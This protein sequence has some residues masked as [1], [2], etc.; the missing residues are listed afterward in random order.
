MGLWVQYPVRSKL[1]RLRVTST[2]SEI[3]FW[4]VFR[5]DQSGASTMTADSSPRP[6][7]KLLLADIGGTNAR[8]ALIALSARSS[9][10][11]CLARAF[12]RRLVENSS[13][14]Q[15]LDATIAPQREQEARITDRMFGIVISDC[16]LT[17]IS[18]IAPLYSRLTL[19]R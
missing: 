19:Q 2:N 11:E 5:T 18:G 4:L 13:T 15:H 14:E 8:F 3:L 1:C 9:L 12:S 10:A 6:N 17:I 16:C 7:G